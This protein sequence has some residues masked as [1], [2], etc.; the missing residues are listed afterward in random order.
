MAILHNGRQIIRK[1][2]GT[3]KTWPAR[4]PWEDILDKMDED[5]PTLRSALS[6]WIDT[7]RQGLT[8]AQ[9][10]SAL[11]GRTVASGLIMDLSG[12]G[13]DFDVVRQCSDYDS[14]SVGE[15][16]YIRIDN[17]NCRIQSQKQYSFR[18]TYTQFHWAGIEIPDMSAA[19]AS[20]TIYP[21]RLINLGY[22]R[23]QNGASA[24]QYCTWSFVLLATGAISGAA[25][26]GYGASSGTRP[27]ICDNNFA[28]Y[29]R[30]N[31]VTKKREFYHHN[32]TD[33][34]KYT[35]AESFYYEYENKLPV[36]LFPRNDK[37]ATT[38]PSYRAFH[39]WLIWFNRM[40]SDAEMQWVKDN[41]Y[42]TA[43]ADIPLPQTLSVSSASPMMMSMDDGAGGDYDDGLS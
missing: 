10:D 25:C 26:T 11:D 6:L 32:G 37:I 16:G 1:Y 31:D 30:F 33:V 18:D 43:E 29:A 20:Q 9:I 22:W 15:D 14:L 42:S 28:W 7:K 21:Y 8:Q 34:Y 12:N 4:Q 5:F 36:F 19:T 40:L 24:N 39:G 41:M 13:G 35:A 23:A 17:E 3:K 38:Q 2:H 27:L